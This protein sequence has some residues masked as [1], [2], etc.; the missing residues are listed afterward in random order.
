[1]SLRQKLHQGELTLGSWITIGN[2][3]IAEMMSKMDFDWLVIDLEHSVIDLS[4]AQNLI[5]IIDLSGTIPLVRVAHNDS[6]M[7]KRVMDA[8]AA[9]VIVPMINSQAQ[10]EAAV[11]AV[12]YP[13]SGSRGVGLARAQAYGIGFDEYRQWLETDSVV[14]V[15]IEHIAAVENLKSILSVDGVDGFIVG[16]YDLSGSLGH[17]G[18]FT[19]PEMGSALRR[20]EEVAKEF[21]SV[22]QGVHVIPPDPA[23]VNQRIENGY[24]FIAASLDTL[25]FQKQCETLFKG[26]VANREVQKGK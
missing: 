11:K 10:A 4:Q 14:I 23:E 9:G 18:E 21:P 19:H 15:Q 1:M 3:I 6:I 2:E 13:P 16:P 24:R 26:I 7:I 8:G 12:R 5:R 25:I 17:P 20:I 22:C